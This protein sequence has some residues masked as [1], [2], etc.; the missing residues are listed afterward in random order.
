VVPLAGFLPVIARSPGDE[1][2]PGV[3][4]CLDC[5]APLATYYEVSV[6]GRGKLF[7]CINLEIP[8]QVR[9]DRGILRRID[10]FFR[11]ITPSTFKIWLNIADFFHIVMLNLFQHPMGSL[12]HRL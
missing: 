10:R 5:F 7:H 6:N 1:A 9:N 3:V 11:H 12:E 2:I 4:E 8:K